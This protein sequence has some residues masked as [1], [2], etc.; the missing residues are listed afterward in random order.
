VVTEVIE[1][2]EVIEVIASRNIL[3]HISPIAIGPEDV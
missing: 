1:D 2:I 3:V